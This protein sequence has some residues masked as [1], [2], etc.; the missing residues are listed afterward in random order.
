[1][2]DQLDR[3]EPQ[4]RR[5]PLDLEAL[6]PIALIV[7]AIV[8]I[9]AVF[10]GSL[11]A[12][13][14][15][16]V[17]NF[18]AGPV[19]DLAIGEVKA[20]EELDFYLVGLPDGRV[21]AVDG[22]VKGNECHVEWLPDDPRGSAANPLGNPGIYVDPCSDG[23]WAMTG[24]ALTAGPDGLEP[25]RTF[26]VEFHTLEDGQQHVFVEVIGRD[27]ALLATPGE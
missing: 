8:S 21:R 25:L 19:T 4:P 18:D 5:V 26:V 27:P 22:R 9:G 11:V 1:M 23:T 2:R 10:W 20:F 16:H 24:D 13:P 17:I 6:T 14:E 12:N 7:V 3:P 15:I